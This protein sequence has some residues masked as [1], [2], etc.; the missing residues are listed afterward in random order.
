[1]K[2][3]IF[4]EYVRVA[5]EQGLVAPEKNIVKNADYADARIGTDTEEVMRMLYNVKPNGDQDILDAA[6]PET[7]VAAPAY[8]G[9]N[10]VI[11]NLK[12]RQNIMG[13][14]ATKLPTGVPTH[15]RYV[16][17]DGKK[18]ESPTDAYREAS[19]D[20]MGSLIRTGFSMDNKDED[21][22]RKLADSCAERIKK[23]A[24]PFAFIAGWLA[25]GVMPVLLTY[26]A[27]ANNFPPSQD[28]MNDLN[29]AI[30]ELE[31]A[32]SEVYAQSQSEMVNVIKVLRQLQSIA[33]NYNNSTS[34]P[35]AKSI[36]ELQAI[37]QNASAM[38]AMQAAQTY[39]NALNVVYSYLPG[40]IIRMKNVSEQSESWGNYLAGL[41]KVKE[42]FVPSDVQDVSKHL[43]TLKDS[44]SNEIKRIQA[45]MR[46][47]QQN[48]Q[49]STEA[50]L[51]RFHKGTG[52]MKSQL[53][54]SP[55]PAKSIGP[56]ES[57]ISDLLRS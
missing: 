38:E 41:K 20:L 13:Y 48:A 23:E 27:F 36:E 14:I 4:D 17:Y 46:Q 1:M 12:E 39:V 10:G 29:Q 3:K 51:A 26:T 45:G 25:K 55:S 21:E 37:Q 2:S 6:H 35:E 47:S 15:R 40:A 5:E 8:D 24:N 33:I 53:V 42:F 19:S 49:K 57:L 44:L 50:T 52:D 11:E 56:A 9:M 28:F 30:E 18:Y 34:I 32:M 16:Y 43:K 54:Q 31:E 22:L 7:M